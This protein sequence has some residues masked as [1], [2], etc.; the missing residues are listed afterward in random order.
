MLISMIFVSSCSKV[1]DSVQKSSTIDNKPI[2]MSEDMTN[3]EMESSILDFIFKL[4]NP[5]GQADMDVE[6]A[7]EYVEAA[8]NY[9]YVNYDYSKC[10]NT[11]EFQGSINIAPDENN[12]MTMSA[13]SLAYDSILNDWSTKYHSVND[14]YKTPIVFDITSLEGNRVE[15]TMIVGKGSIDLRD[16]SKDLVVPTTI[17][18][19]DGAYY[20]QNQILNY[21]N[22]TNISY[23]NRSYFVLIG[24]QW[25]GPKGSINSND[26]TPGDGYIDYQYFYTNI[27]EP[28][29]HLF[30]HQYEYDYYKDSYF[31]G[32]SDFI[33]STPSVNATSYYHIGID[34]NG[35]AYNP[36]AN[37]PTTPN[38]LWHIPQVFY[39]ERYITANGMSTL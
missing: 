17:Y 37:P 39:G 33:S 9:K 7:F 18:H 29:Y 8:L 20:I 23:G 34:F 2:R 15:Y 11:V 1:E 26:P 24:M 19:A 4:D 10:A 3:D 30:W 21:L 32:L 6:E 22:N 31:D 36:N 5:E 28:G 27:A 35:P 25:L 14:E 13:I 12:M 16:Y 38:I